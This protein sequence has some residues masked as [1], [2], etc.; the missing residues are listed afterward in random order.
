MCNHLVDHANDYHGPFL[1]EWTGE[2][3]F[4]DFKDD[5]FAVACVKA[6]CQCCAF[7]QAQFVSE[8]V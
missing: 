2:P 8:L 4:V 1:A 6:D 3:L 5:G 7:G